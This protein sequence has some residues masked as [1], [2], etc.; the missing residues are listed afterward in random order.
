[1]NRKAIIILVSILISVCQTNAQTARQLFLDIPERVLDVFTKNDR[2]D[3]FD[4]LDS[5]MKAVVKNKLNEESEMTRYSENYIRLAISKEVIWEMKLLPYKDNQKIIC[6]IETI[7]REFKNST[8]SFYTTEW[9]EIEKERFIPQIYFEEYK[10]E[11]TTDE[12]KEII[13]SILISLDEENNK[14]TIKQE[15]LTYT[16]E[17]TLERERDK[18]GSE[19]ILR[20]DREKFVVE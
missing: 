12:S 16:N 1:M 6:C 8:I 14:I 9:E 13:M 5:N 2:A 19:I 17:E 11:G 7:G 20:W 10:E 3:F 15:R 4:F 18:K